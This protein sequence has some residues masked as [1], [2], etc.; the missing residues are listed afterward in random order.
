MALSG[1]GE[2]R[3]WPPAPT[4]RASGYRSSFGWICW[5][6]WIWFIV[7][8]KR[9]KQQRSQAAFIFGDENSAAL[10]HARWA[11]KTQTHS[12]HQSIITRR[13][14]RV[15]CAGNATTRLRIF[16]AGGCAPH[17]AAISRLSLN[18]PVMRRAFICC[19][20]RME[21]AA[22]CA[23][24]GLR[25]AA[26]ISSARLC[27]SNSGITQ[28]ARRAG[29]CW[30]SLARRRAERAAATYAVLSRRRTTLLLRRALAMPRC[31]AICRLQRNAAQKPCCI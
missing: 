3:E 5:V 4:H 25:G 31:S 30:R 23:C 20:A 18:A 6:G 13:A 17:R 14:L 26:S 27:C 1:R 22:R 7:R 8:V 12:R 29:A 19:L 28:T 10:H 9:A 11:G 2:G 15:A 24:F 21:R 16:A